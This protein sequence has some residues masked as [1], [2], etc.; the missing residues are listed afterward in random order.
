MAAA[1]VRVVVA[2]LAIV[3]SAA[4]AG[5]DEVITDDLIVDGSTCIGLRCSQDEVFGF[6]TL[7]L[8]G[9]ELRL[10]FI[11]T[12]STAS[13]P[14]TD[15]RITINDP[16]TGAASRFS[17]D[18]LDAGTTPLT[19]EA[20][21]P[22]HSLYVTG[23]GRLGIG[24]PTPAPGVALD[25]RGNLRVDGNL[26]VTGTT[27]GPVGLKA[28]IVPRSAFARGQAAV[29]F[30]TPYTGD[31]LVL[32]TAVS[33]RASKEIKPTVVARDANGFTIATSRKTARKIVEVHWMTQ[34]VGE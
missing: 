4:V 15:W 2:L 11:D 12:S 25:V 8:K 32:L 22:S 23:D 13:F 27:T 3:G 21:A 26:S 1:N 31:Y 24:T 29:T 5:A 34:P 10:S 33:S 20:G 7:R 18:D 16:D 14:T 9:D 28:G 19:I 6:D 30:A 17:I